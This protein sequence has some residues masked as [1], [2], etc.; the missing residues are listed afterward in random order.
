MENFSNETI[1][2]LNLPRYEDVA[3][4]PLHFSYLRIIY[5]NIAFWFVIIDI[6]AAA[7]FYFIEEIRLYW[8]P[9]T[10]SYLV[11]M[12]I[13]LLVQ[14]ISFKNKGFAFRTH[15][16]I[17]QSGAIAITNTVIPYTRIQHVAQHEGLLSR[18]FGLATVEIYTAGGVGG[19]IKIPG[20]EKQ[21]ATAI[22]KLLTGK[23]EQKAEEVTE[24]ST[25]EEIIEINPDKGYAE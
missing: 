21:H 24:K 12:L 25:G 2:T 23:V 5:I 18:W 16:V 9:V 14:V 19:D 20:L 1:D 10:L 11:I 15:D 3:L 17:Y 6:A 13:V 8:L 4:T 7:A 22:K